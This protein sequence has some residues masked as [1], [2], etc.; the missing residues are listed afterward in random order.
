MPALRIVW[1]VDSCCTGVA[2]WA[3]RGPAVAAI[4]MAEIMYC[5]FIL[6]NG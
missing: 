6:C 2:D 5:V 1:R 3:M 4:M